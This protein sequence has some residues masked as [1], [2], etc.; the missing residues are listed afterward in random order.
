MYM[1][2]RGQPLESRL[3]LSPFVFEAESV[4]H[5]AWNSP[6]STEWLASAVQGCE[7]LT[8]PVLGLQVCATMLGFLFFKIY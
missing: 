6:N 4:S 1:E 3:M 2:V 5:Q 8:S 7:C